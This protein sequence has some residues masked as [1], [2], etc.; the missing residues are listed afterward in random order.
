MA[1]IDNIEGLLE[2]INSKLD[3]FL[4]FEDLSDEER[5]E[6]ETIRKAVRSGETVQFDD[7][8]ED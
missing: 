2:K 7:V 4:G 3:N 5:E 8:F 1:K 6:I